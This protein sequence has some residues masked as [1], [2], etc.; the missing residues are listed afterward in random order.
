MLKLK[1]GLLNCSAVLFET[2]PCPPAVSVA[3]PFLL[4]PIPTIPPP[5]ATEVLTPEGPP[6]AEPPDTGPLFPV[7]V[8]E[9]RLSKRIYYHQKSFAEPLLASSLLALI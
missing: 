3:G 6:P 2:E 7:T 9:A 8:P 1:P 4:A 5:P